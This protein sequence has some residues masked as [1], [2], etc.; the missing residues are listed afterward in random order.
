LSLRT[1]TQLAELRRH[2]QSVA[3]L[4][5]ELEQAEDFPNETAR[6]FCTVVRCS[7][8]LIYDRLSTAPIDRLP[9]I[10]VLL[11]T[12]GEDLRYAERSR[13]EHTPWSL[14]KPM[15]IFLQRKVGSEYR[16]IIRP[17]WSYNYA[18]VG[19]LLATYRSYFSSFPD[20][21]PLSDWHAVIGDAGSHHIYSISFPRV[22]KMN[23]LT[24]AAWGHEV[25]HILI[26]DW[27][28]KHFD[29]MWQ[30]AAPDI[31][32]AIRSEVEKQLEE[33][34][35]FVEQIVATYLNDTLSLTRQSLKELVSDAVGA[36]F[37]GPAALASLCEF[38]SRFSLD[39]N[40]V[41]G[42]GYPP[43]RYRLRMLSEMVL[44][45]LKAGMADNWHP[46]LRACVDWL[47]E[48]QKITESNA[49]RIAIESDVRSRKAYE[50]IEADYTTICADVIKQL[51]EE[52]QVPYT[53]T[54]RLGEIGELI[55]RIELGVPPN[56]TGVWPNMTP[57][58]VPDI[59]NA[60]WACK[61]SRFRSST[62]AE[63]DEILN[64]LLRL[65]LK[66]MEASYVHS[67]FRPLIAS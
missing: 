45:D 49:D 60:A 61:V 3:Q 9:H 51:R 42:G 22:E 56:E 5:E 54:A 30:K 67:T 31:E 62:G 35:L 13:V 15:E 32:R 20:W 57:A 55:D 14:V 17:Q 39:E 23:V 6:E 8:K 65:T 28:T 18:I 48:W 11:A 19:D 53:L 47:T 1:D 2:A 52:L 63:F 38:S 50:L 27:M 16:F 29:N 10:H 64:M 25:G 24:H 33:A 40:P 21:I 59:W 44:P 34:P 43:W 46:S 4:A 37:L 7:A 58:E 36:H 26:S 66:A 41:D 12:L